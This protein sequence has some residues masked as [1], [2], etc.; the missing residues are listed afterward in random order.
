MRFISTFLL[1]AFCFLNATI[2]EAK[3]AR[4]DEALFDAIVFALFNMEEGVAKSG[5]GPSLKRTIREPY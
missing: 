1:F 3:L 5:T 4:S 2:S